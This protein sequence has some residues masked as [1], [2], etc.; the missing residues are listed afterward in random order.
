MVKLLEPFKDFKPTIR[1]WSGSPKYKMVREVKP[2]E[3]PLKLTLKTLKKIVRKLRKQYPS[4]DYRLEKVKLHDKIYYCLRRGETDLKN[5]PIY[6]DLETGR[7]YIPQTYVKRKKRLVASV[8][9]YRLR[10]LGAK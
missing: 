4:H 7:I 6:I 1:G 9:D 10:S 5:P 8:I 2:K 3:Y